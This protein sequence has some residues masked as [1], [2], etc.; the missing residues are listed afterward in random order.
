MHTYYKMVEWN[1]FC[2][3]H[4]KYINMGFT[5]QHVGKT[6]ATQEIKF[7]IL[8]NAHFSIFIRISELQITRNTHAIIFQEHSF[9]RFQK[10]LF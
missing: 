5:M 1:K 2:P 3:L 10:A 4:L 6:L 7:F 8:Q 9:K